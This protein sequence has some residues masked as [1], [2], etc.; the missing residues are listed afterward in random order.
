MSS[1]SISPVKRHEHTK[2]QPH[3]S[4]AT[5]NKTTFGKEEGRKGLSKVGK[6]YVLRGLK[7]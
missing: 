3:T 7:T 6:M 2:I 1:F 5:I 4:K